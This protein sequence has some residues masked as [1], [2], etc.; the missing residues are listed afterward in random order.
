MAH[1]VERV[2]QPGEG[3]RG[4]DRLVAPI[5]GKQR[6]DVLE[7][8]DGIVGDLVVCCC[9]NTQLFLCQPLHWL[10]L[11]IQQLEIH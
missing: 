1:A 4:L 7:D 11:S 8:H 10:V 2:E 6:V 5:L 3:Q 9:K